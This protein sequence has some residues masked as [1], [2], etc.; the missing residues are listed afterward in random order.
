MPHGVAGNAVADLPDIVL[1]HLPAR[2]VVLMLRIAL[3]LL[4]IR[5]GIRRQRSGDHLQVV[6]GDLQIG[7]KGRYD[8]LAV[9]GGLEIDV[10]GQHLQNL[11][12][13]VVLGYNHTADD[14]FDGEPRL[15]AVAVSTAAVSG[16][17]SAAK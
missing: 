1:D 15:D 4:H 5:L 12:K 8:V 2:L 7:C 17:D 11:Y 14:V 16:L 13:A 9:I 10:D 6:G 3:H